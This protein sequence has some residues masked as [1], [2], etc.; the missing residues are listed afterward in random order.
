[1]AK[2]LDL[3]VEGTLGWEQAQV[4]AGGVP[5]CEIDLGTMESRICPGLYICGELLDA[6]GRC[7]GYNLHWAFCTGAAAGEQLG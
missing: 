6:D 3:P 4:T 7:G 1:M 2:G 5:L